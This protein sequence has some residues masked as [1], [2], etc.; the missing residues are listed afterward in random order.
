[1]KK[2]IKIVLILIAAL[3][4]SDFSNANVCDNDEKELD[5]N[6][7]NS[8]YCA[9]YNSGV[10]IHT[11]QVLPPSLL[12][13][14]NG[15]RCIKIRW[16]ADYEYYKLNGNSTVS[17]ISSI[18]RKVE[19]IYAG[20]SIDLNLITTESKVYK[21]ED[22][23]PYKDST[24]DGLPN[25]PGDGSNTRIGK[26]LQKLISNNVCNSNDVVILFSGNEKLENHGIALSNS[27][28]GNLARQV[29]LG[30]GVADKKGRTLTTHQEA[31]IHAHELG[32]ILS[33]SKL[34]PTCDKKDKDDE[35]HKGYHDTTGI[36]HCGIP[37]TQPGNN[38]FIDDRK[39]Q[40]ITSLNLDCYKCNNSTPT[41]T[42]CNNSNNGHPVAFTC[43]YGCD[44]GLSLN[45]SIL[46]GRPY[47]GTIS[48]SNLQII[49]NGNNSANDV[50][51]EYALVT[52][53]GNQSHSL[54]T[55]PVV[56]SIAPGEEITPNG[57]FFWLTDIP[58][59]SYQLQAKL[60]S[61]LGAEQSC[62]SMN[63]IY[64]G[65]PP[66]TGESDLTFI[67]CGPIE[68]ITE[69]HLIK[70]KYKNQGVGPA[71][72]TNIGVYLSADTNLDNDDIYITDQSIQ[73]LDP[74][75]EI[76]FSIPFSIDGLPLPD[77]DVYIILNADNN[78][79]ALESNEDNNICPYQLNRCRS[80]NLRVSGNLTANYEA[81][82]YIIAP[83]PTSS[84][85]NKA[86]IQSTA[87]VNFKAG[88]YIDL[89]PGFT[90]E[91]GSKFLGYIKG[92]GI[93]SM[94]EK[95][96]TEQAPI[97][98]RNYPNP[99]TGQTNIEFVLPKD[100]P[101]T[102]F[103]SD[104]TGRKVAMLLNNEQQTEGVH[105][106]TFDGSN[107]PAGIYYYTIQAGEYIGTQKMILA[108]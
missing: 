15:T 35:E 95:E 72:P 61:D 107:Y 75:Y 54:G 21:T 63:Q 106:L 104:M 62:I 99:F 83:V 77:G 71:P 23:D 3:A 82:N 13:T 94:N 50:K 85:S 64:I 48:V 98:L 90:A 33:S 47:N 45:C 7:S 5:D 31:R 51:I 100:S 44:N 58:D 76:H 81:T 66:P 18:L 59:G 69:G 19:D 92:C 36:M 97:T 56:A 29:G 10:T 93:P 78:N 46:E 27:S 52:L 9:V 53:V 108:K 96:T 40:I 41:P 25:L 68:K 38:S 55:K 105:L 8:H 26:V 79:V 86:T 70:Y 43:G 102:L 28:R 17:R 101:V 1:M 103:V 42:I 57:Q 65:I 20:N 67:S 6:Q 30:I 80:N 16:E 73:A 39:N 60:V 89:I 2:Y 84:N 24:I 11:E 4:L 34:S 32:H 74:D 12:T 87:N 37:Y 22:E 88:K 91:Y 49:N 14:L